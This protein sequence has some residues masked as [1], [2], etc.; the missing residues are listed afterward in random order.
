M[1][2]LNTECPGLVPIRCPMIDKKRKPKPEEIKLV[3]PEAFEREAAILFRVPS[4]EI[5]N[6]EPARP[7]RQPRPAKSTKPKVSVSVPAGWVFLDGTERWVSEKDA[8][9]R[10]LDAAGGGVVPTPQAKK[11]RRRTAD[12]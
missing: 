1:A 4:A 11:N 8:E 7:R 9:T 6:A 12:S 10:T 3:P 2:E 5:K